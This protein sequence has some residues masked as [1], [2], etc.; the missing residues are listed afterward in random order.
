MSTSHES[1]TLTKYSPRRQGICRRIKDYRQCDSG[2]IGVRTMCHARWTI[3]MDALGSTSA[4][5]S[6]CIVLQSMWNYPKRA[7]YGDEGKNSRRFASYEHISLP[8]RDHAWRTTAETRRQLELNY[9][10]QV[11][12]A[13]NVNKW[14][15]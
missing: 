4:S 5:Y 10:T 1:I 11:A 2:R 14:R 3:Q 8:I 12:S 7:R 6:N 15:R 13:T 9:A